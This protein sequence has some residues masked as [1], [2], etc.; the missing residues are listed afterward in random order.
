MVKQSSSLAALSKSQEE[1]QTEVKSELKEIKDNMQI[2]HDFMVVQKDRQSDLRTP[3][4][5]INWPEV[6]KQGLVFLTVAA[7]IILVI[8][9]VLAEKVNK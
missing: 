9:Q 1:F 8:V 5:N 4:G 7:S 6:I 2:F 3:K